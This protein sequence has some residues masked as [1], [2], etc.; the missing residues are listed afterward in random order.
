MARKKEYNRDEVLKAATKVFWTKGFHGTSISDLVTATGLN[1]HSMYA[2]FKSK[3]GLYLACLNTYANDIQKY[4]YNMLTH[5][6]LGLGN[7]E[8]F[9]RN[10]VAYAST[11]ECIGCMVINSTVEK[12]LIEREA[13]DLTQKHLAAHEELIV[14]NFEAALKNG[15]VNKNSDP[16]IL[17]KYVLNFA[18]GLM[19]IGKAKQD[20]ETLEE[21]LEIL[22]TT[23]K[24]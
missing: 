18:A 3:E 24:K 5:E 9:L 4:I 21:M 14:R 11:K 16:R 17:A 2:E 12:E 19:V 6:P 10:R 8:D 13:F 20:K 1:K 7:V 15:E 22:L 23:L